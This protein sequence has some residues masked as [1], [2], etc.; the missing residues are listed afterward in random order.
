M[1]LPFTTFLGCLGG[2]FTDELRQLRIG[3]AAFVVRITEF[4]VYLS[5]ASHERAVKI[6]DFLL[7]E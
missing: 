2:I 5:D 4:F 3:N 1:E 6:L 7:I